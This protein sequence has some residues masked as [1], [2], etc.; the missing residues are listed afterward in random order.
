L[1]IFYACFT[2]LL[3]GGFDMPGDEI[4][5]VLTISKAS[6]VLGVSENVVI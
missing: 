5:H 4:K 6:E 2:F 3:L 1:T